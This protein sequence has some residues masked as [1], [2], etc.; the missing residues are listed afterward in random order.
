MEYKSGENMKLVR[1]ADGQTNVL[2]M[3][4][5][6]SRQKRSSVASRGDGIAFFGISAQNHAQS[7]GQI[8]NW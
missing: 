6:E 7:I 8:G 2:K 4:K 3:P 5:S 1:N